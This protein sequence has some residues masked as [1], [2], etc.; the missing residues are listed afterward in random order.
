MSREQNND[1]GPSPEDMQRKTPANHRVIYIEN[2]ANADSD[3][4][5]AF[6]GQ[7]K[8]L[9]KVDAAFDLGPEIVRE[10]LESA[11]EDRYDGIVTHVP[12]DY[13]TTSYRTI[14][15]LLTDLSDGLNVPLIA[16]TG[17]GDSD[18]VQLNGYVDHYVRKSQDPD[19]DAIKAFNALS[20]MWDRLD[21]IKTR[22]R[23]ITEENGVTVLRGN[24]RHNEVLGLLGAG[25]IGKLCKQYPG[26]VFVSFEQ[27][28]TDENPWTVNGDSIMGLL[29]MISQA[30]H[31]L[32]FDI[33]GTGSDARELATRLAK[34]ISKRSELAITREDLT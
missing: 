1:K 6:L 25:A 22:T 7:L 11:P 16:Y 23:E 12:H 4:Y 28:K 8:D 18:V 15:E 13:R 2:A 17:M 10:L 31:P 29:V 27:V 5:R 21:D 3:H 9:C 33:S 30:D 32:R 34:I 26:D 24:I 19:S 14:F 20:G